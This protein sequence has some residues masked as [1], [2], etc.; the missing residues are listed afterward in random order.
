MCSSK[1]KAKDTLENIFC[2]FKVSPKKQV[3]TN[4]GFGFNCVM[5]LS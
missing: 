2:L 3:A 5:G 1:T 4:Y